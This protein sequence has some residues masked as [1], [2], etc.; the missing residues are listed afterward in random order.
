[1]RTLK[2]DFRDCVGLVY[3]KRPIRVEY[4][5]EVEHCLSWDQWCINEDC[6]YLLPQK[7]SLWNYF[8]GRC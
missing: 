3:Y 1:M 5:K 6:E 4:I 8:L 7:F 2:D